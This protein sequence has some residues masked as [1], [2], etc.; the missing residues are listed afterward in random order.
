MVL[1]IVIYTS[2]GGLAAVA[3]TDTFMVICMT[4][5]AIYICFQMFTDIRPVRDDRAA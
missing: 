1:V 2:M 5:S 4:I 3:W